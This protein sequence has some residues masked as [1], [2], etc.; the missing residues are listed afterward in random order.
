MQKI[1]PF[2]WFDNNAE[3]AISFYTTIF[4]N[5]K[6][7]W[8]NRGLDGQVFTGSFQLNGQDFMAL[9]GGPVFKFTPAVSFFVS[10]T[11]KEEI[12]QLW[13]KL[14]KDGTVLMKLDKY[15]FSE[16]YGWIN[17]KY[18]V[19]WQ[20][21]LG[22]KDQ[23]FSPCL[24]FIGKQCG[25]A[26]EAIKFYTSVFNNSKTNYVY[27]YTPGLGEPESNV[28]HAGFSLEGQEFIAMDSSKKHLFTLNEAVSFFV[29]CETQEEVDY[30]WAKLSE[31]GKEGQCGWLKDKYEVSW[32]V[33]PTILGKLMGDKDPIK[34]QKVMQAMIKM[35]KISIKQLEEAYDS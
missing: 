14:S 11:T 10:C 17:D 35:T 33:V 32:Q 27:H 30:F 18:G 34:S 29:T 13:E 31:G 7:T 3:E 20:L 24:M 28:M 8:L 6:V 25:K 15:P 5:S 9:N 21:F 22:E 26:E 19:S 2:L 12:D 4:K 23:T 16:K 1:T